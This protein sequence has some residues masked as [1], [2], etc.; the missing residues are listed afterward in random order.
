M[1]RR[2]IL[3]LIAFIYFGTL[4]AESQFGYISYSTYNIGDDIQT[5]AAKRFLPDD[6]V[7]IDREFIGAFTAE[8]QIRVLIN[9]WY[10]HTK[11]NNWY[12]KDIAP[13]KKSWPPSPAIQPLLISIHFTKDFAPEVFSKESIDYLKQNGPIGARDFTTLQELQKRDI[14]SYFSGCLTLTLENPYRDYEREDIIYAVDLDEEC[15]KYIRSKTKSKVVPVSHFVRGKL[16]F[17]HE[18]RMAYAEELL[19]KYRK[20]KCVITSRLHASMPCLAF[21]TP[22]LLINT[23]NDQYR[24]DGL[25]DLVRNCSKR[26]FIKGFVDFDID[27]PSAN[28]KTYLPLRNNLIDIINQWLT[29]STDQWSFPD[30]SMNNMTNSAKFL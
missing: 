28:P 29:G 8:S 7:A 17:D 19:D 6:S 14:P 21:E 5:I 25:K 16:Q 27:H 22:V 10:M 15:I 1:S 4:F 18:L 20:A 3:L 12:R 9:G 26:S 23:Q 13:P 2:F 24:F 30:D 11:N